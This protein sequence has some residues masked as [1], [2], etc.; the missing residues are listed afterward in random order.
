MFFLNNELSSLLSKNNSTTVTNSFL[1]IF[2]SLDTRRGNTSRNY[3][4]HLGRRSHIILYGGYKEIKYSYQQHKP[5]IFPGSLILQGVIRADS[6]KFTCRVEFED[7]PTQTHKLQ[8]I[9]YG[10]FYNA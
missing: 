8:L 2:G 1:Y 4:S 5:P 6:G 9:V 3:N 10:E 7:S